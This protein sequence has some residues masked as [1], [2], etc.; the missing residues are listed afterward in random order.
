[1]SLHIGFLAC[2][3]GIEEITIFMISISEAIGIAHGPPRSP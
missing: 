3:H 1:M 2:F